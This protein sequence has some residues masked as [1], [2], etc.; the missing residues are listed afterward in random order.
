MKKVILGL[1]I[2]PV[3]VSGQIAENFESG[4]PQNWIQ[5]TDL[6]WEADTITAISGSFSLHHVYDSP[7]SGSDQIATSIKDLFPSEGLTRWSFLV[8]HGYDPS[9]S[10]N[11]CVFLMSDNGPPEM[12]PGGSC[13]GFAVGVNLTGYDDTL[14]LWK[15][16][17]GVPSVVVTTSLNWQN[18]VGIYS[19][20]RIEITRTREGTWEII[21]SDISGT[22]TGTGTGTESDLF[23]ISWFG[24]YY[25]YSSTRDRLLWLDEISVDGPFIEDYVPIQ[26]ITGDVVIT[27]I[28]ADPF[29]P[30]T[31]PEAE[32]LEIFN[33]SIKRLNLRN[34][35]IRYEDHRAIFP[36]VYI[37]PGEFLLVCSVSDTSALAGYGKTTGLKSFPSL[38]DDGRWLALYNSKGEIIHSLCYSDSWYGNILKSDGGWSLEMIDT[39]YPFYEKGNWRASVSRSGGT[40]GSINS[41]SGTN[42]DNNFRGIDNVFPVDSLKVVVTFSE[43]VTADSADR[44]VIKID[45]RDITEALRFHEEGKE[46]LVNTGIVMQSG[47]CY[48]LSCSENIRDFAG[49]SAERRYFGFGLPEVAR[50]QDIIINEILFN[51][52]PG[53]EDFVEM[54][55]RSGNIVDVSQLFLVSVNDATG[56]TS[57]LYRLSDMGRCFM[58]GEYMVFSTDAESVFSRYHTCS[59]NN[60]FQVN[61]LPS[62]PDDRGHLVLLNRQMETIDEIRYDEKMHFPLLSDNEGFSLERLN[63][64]YDIWHSASEVSGGATP[65]CPNSVYSEDDVE[66][67]FV[68]LSSTRITPDNDGNDDL[69]IINLNFPGFGEVISVLIFSETGSLVRRLAENQLAGSDNMLAWDATGDDGSLVDRGIYIIYISSFNEYG[70]KKNWK[71][72]CTVLR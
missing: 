69:L 19:P 58:P 54:Y 46:L 38:T 47:I 8:R 64:D 60:V 6:H 11:W 51:P 10:N 49:N 22:V 50:I 66:E 59:D 37:D 41:V 39:D 33:R 45:D 26:A 65:G 61:Q 29:P 48:T 68:T 53:D 31:L 21:L 36:D 15:L 44:Q 20:S 40:P 42:T 56:D 14:R 72:V 16:K 63:P 12:M 5:Q 57:S 9:S 35:E 52:I 2:L 25:E 28:M 18:D 24:V 1:W 7:E 4:I 71:K 55:N 3:L 30:V 13:Y 23:D 67:S 32:Y 34:W 70:R 43:F 62:M 27:E 17:N